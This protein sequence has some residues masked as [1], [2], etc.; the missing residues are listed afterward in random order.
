MFPNLAKYI[1]KFFELFSYGTNKSKSRIEL[2]ERKDISIDEETYT[3]LKYIISSSHNMLGLR[4]E[5]IPA[6]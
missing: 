6:V 4:V 2:E 1:K 3:E 5:C